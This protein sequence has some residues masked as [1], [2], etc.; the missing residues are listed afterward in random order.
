[1][2]NKSNKVFL[3]FFL[4][5]THAFAQDSLSVLFL[6]NS[7][8]SYNNLPAL[9][10]NLSSAASKSLFTD[11]YTPGGYTI[12]G[13]LTDPISLNKIRTGR[14]DYIIIQEQSQLPTID[15]YRYN[16]MYPSLAEIKDTISLYNPCAKIITYMTWGRR[17]GGQQC[18]Q[19]ATYCSPNFA[20]FNQMQDSLTNAYL[21]ISN[22]LH[23]QCAPV[24]AVWQNVL[25]DTSL[26]LHISDN[27]HPNL[28]GSYIAACAI[29][30]SIWKQPS[31]GLASV[32][33]LSNER[34][35]YYQQ[36]ADFTLFN[37]I[38]NWN[39]NINK[40][41]ANFSALVAGDSASFNNLT[42]FEVSDSLA[43]Y[44]NFGDSSISREINPTHTY[45]NPG[46]YTVTLIASHCSASDTIQKNINILPKEIQLNNY[47]IF[48]NPTANQILINWNDH[49]Q[50][51]IELIN[52][53]GQK[54]K[55]FKNVL[56][57]TPL[58]LSN[59][60]NGIYFIRIYEN[61][62]VITKKVIISH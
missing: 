13:H 49:E 9:V 61:Q 12:Y 60:P 26:V 46:S 1:M 58:N 10:K 16:Q 45:L 43:Y 21:Q 35:H 55:I 17:Y 28:D 11:S 62:N 56:S 52:T 27:S 59:L 51:N 57:N 33:G 53:C 4:I 29:F 23:I 6:G 54:V 20:D 36:M 40:P 24:G 22:L 19:S 30:S 8:T 44:W 37:G 25:N 50:R 39:L 42:T 48:P 31:F 2:L 14:W 15:Y 7:Y 41:L 18:D 34:A 47:N 38:N 32:S 3:L 5:T